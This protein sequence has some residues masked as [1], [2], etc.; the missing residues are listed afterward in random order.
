LSDFR[1]DDSITKEF[2]LINEKVLNGEILPT[3]GA[4]H[5]LSLYNSFK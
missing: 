5:L 2:K 3:E 4:E 1:N